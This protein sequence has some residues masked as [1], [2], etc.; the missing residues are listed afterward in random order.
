M[1]FPPY[2]YTPKVTNGMFTLDLKVDTVITLSTLQ[3]QQK[4]VYPNIPKS[5]PFPVKYM[6]DFNSKSSAK[7]Y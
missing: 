4:G 6:D 7:A 5:M 2:T 1:P 3:G